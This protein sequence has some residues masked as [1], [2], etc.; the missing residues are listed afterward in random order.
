MERTLFGN[1]IFP[2]DSHLEIDGE[3]ASREIYTST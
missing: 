3:T 1:L 2:L